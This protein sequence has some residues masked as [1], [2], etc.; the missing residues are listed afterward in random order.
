MYN[1]T[2]HKSI[3]YD[4]PVLRFTSSAKCNLEQLR[5]FGCIAYAKLPKTKTKFSKVTIKT[6]LVD[7]LLLDIFCGIQVQEN[8]WNLGM[9]DF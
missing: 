3:K 2:P 9:L 4:V 1:I 8:S 7:I 5:R 6:I